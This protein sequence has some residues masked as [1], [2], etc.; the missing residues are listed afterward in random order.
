[1]TFK[2]KQDGDDAWNYIKK[3][4]GIALKNILEQIA[5]ENSRK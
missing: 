1:M 2:Y 4:T 5:E 3:Y